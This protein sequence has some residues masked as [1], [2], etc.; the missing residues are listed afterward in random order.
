MN[1]K[2]LTA[3]TVILFAMAITGYAYTH[4]TD[5]IQ[6]QGNIQLAK[7]Q[8]T[9]QAHNTTLQTTYQNDHALNLTGT[10]NSSNKTILT[11]IIIN[12][13]GTTPVNIQQTIQTNATDNTLQN[14]TLYYGPYTII[15]PEKWDKAPT[16][17]PPDGQTTPPE[18]RTQQILIVWLNITIDT[19]SITVGATIQITVNYTATFQSW[20]D[21]ITINYILTYQEGGT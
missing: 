9:L 8:I 17:P 15:P 16:L 11:G 12:N 13:T 2:L 1:K 3:F 18:L 21:T 19:S 10:I 6:I 7:T 20:T 5:I 4:W 14:Q